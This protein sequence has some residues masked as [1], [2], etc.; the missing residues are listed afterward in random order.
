MAAAAL[1]VSLIAVV[2]RPVRVAPFAILVA[3][4]AAGIGGRHSRLAA[5]AVAVGGVSFVAG[6][7]VAVIT[8]HAIY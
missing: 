8:G 4:I 1:F 7:V 6:M 3:L 5:L 2:Y